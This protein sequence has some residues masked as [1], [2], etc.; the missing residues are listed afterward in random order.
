MA[1]RQ[2][3]HDRIDEI[4]SDVLRMGG[5][6]NDMVRLAV[7]ATLNGDTELAT[8]V[9]SSDDA[10]DAVER[11]VVHKTV[12]TVMQ[13]S[14]VATELRM[15]VS[16]LG[17]VSEIEKVGDDAVKLARRASKLTGKFPSEMKLALME[18]GEHARRSFSSALRLY[19]HYD[20]ALAKE[21][22]LADKEIDTAYSHARGRVFELIQQDP[23]A[24]EH[25][26]RTIEAFHAL[27][28]VADHAVAIAVRLQMLYATG[29]TVA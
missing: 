15:L 29:R 20:P 22:I 28:H 27:E 26:V 14:P 7:E 16:T 25:L 5:M 8:R 18:L 2:H 10:I 6:A 4:R 24:T 3:Y 9:I 19:S 11:D 23:K 21:V 1:L 12:V 17:V 13:E